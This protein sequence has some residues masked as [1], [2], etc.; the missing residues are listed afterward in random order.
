MKNLLALAEDLIPAVY[1]AGEI[2]LKYF[3]SGV[4]AIDKDDGSPVTLAD[5]EAEALIL[6]HLARLAPE[7]PVVG[8]ESVAAGSVPDISAGTFFLVDPL[9]GTRDFITG[10]GE[11]TVNIGL[12]VDFR[13]VMGIIYSP[14]KGDLYYGAE[15]QAFH[16]AKGAMAQKISTRGKPA[17]GLT[18]VTRKRNEDMEQLENFLSTLHISKIENYSS[19]IKFCAVAAGK[20]DVYPRFSPTSEW[21]TAA[22]EAILRAAG[23]EVVQP[24]GTPMTYGK[25]GQKFLNGHFIARS[26]AIVA[27]DS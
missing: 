23:G 13:P 18:V 8:E 19:S 22:G 14:L 25:A 11:F 17:A 20:A 4:E 2:E 5:Q 10:S 1:E 21:D 27:S 12:L 16:A 7:I 24:D 9:D 26:R 6:K 15:G 3:N